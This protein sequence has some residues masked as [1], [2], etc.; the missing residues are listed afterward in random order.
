VN[1]FF[2]PFQIVT[3]VCELADGHRVVSGS[4]DKQLR[5]WNVDSGVCER[6][7]HGHS[8]VVVA[9]F[10]LKLLPS[11][12]C[13]SLCPLRCSPIGLRIARSINSCLGRG[14]RYL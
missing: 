9:P 14:G 5:V 12:S 8:E 4:Q 7:L 3:S 13:D 11:D 1:M 6:V 10:V 2:C